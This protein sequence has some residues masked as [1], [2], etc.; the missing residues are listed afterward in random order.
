MRGRLILYASVAL[1]II[2]S[3]HSLT[4]TIA[5]NPVRLLKHVF[6]GTSMLSARNHVIVKHAQHPHV[7]R[8]DTRVRY[9]VYSIQS[10]ILLRG[11]TVKP[12]IPLNKI[13]K[14]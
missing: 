5:I 10:G 2:Q 1:V 9:I 8:S 14:D 6:T 12:S 11:T 3:N 4:R 7:V 13:L